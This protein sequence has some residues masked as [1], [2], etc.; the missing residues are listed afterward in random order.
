MTDLSPSA[1]AIAMLYYDDVSAAQEWLSAVFELETTT[2]H[3]DPDG[4]VFAAEMSIGA[5]RVMLLGSREDASLGMRSP[6]TVGSMTGGVYVTL[7]NVDRHYEH[8]V[9]A[10]ATIVMPIQVMDYGSREYGALD[11]EGHYWGFGSYQLT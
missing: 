7:D 5:G 2:K 10:G 6:R 11:C 3:Q 1:S 8:S 9:Q 4:V